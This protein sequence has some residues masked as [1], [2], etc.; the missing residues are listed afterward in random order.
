MNTPDTFLVSVTN[1]ELSFEEDMELPS[2]IPVYE[3]CR[4]ILMI[5]KEIHGDIFSGWTS[6]RLECSNRLLNGD[7]TLTKAAVFD[8]S[9]IIVRE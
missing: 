5:L 6:C 3:L 4:Q 1:E 8:G 9:R 7:D 2:E